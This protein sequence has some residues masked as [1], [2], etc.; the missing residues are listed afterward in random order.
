MGWWSW[1]CC[2]LS[3]WLGRRSALT[4]PCSS[5]REGRA[6]RTVGVVSDGAWLNGGVLML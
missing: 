4:A 6:R 5:R 1:S 3:L 2:G